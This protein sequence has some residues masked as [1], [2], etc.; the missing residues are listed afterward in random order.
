MSEKGKGPPAGCLSPEGKELVLPPDLSLEERWG[1]IGDDVAV[2]I[3]LEGLRPKFHSFPPLC[4]NPPSEALTCLRQTQEILKFVPD[5]LER[6][7]IR[8]V[9]EPAL[10]Y[11]S[12]MFTVAKKNG[13]RCPILDLS[14][15]NRLIVTPKFRMETLDKVVKLIVSSMWGTSIDITDAYLHVLINKGFQKYFSFILGVRTFVFL[16]MP[17]GLIP[18]FQANKGVSSSSRDNSLFIPR[19]FSYPSVVIPRG[20]STHQVDR[21]SFGVARLSDQ[22]RKVVSSPSPKAGISRHCVRSSFSNNF[23][24]SGQS[25]ESL[26]SLSSRSK[27]LLDVKKGIGKFGRFPEFCYQRP[28]VGK[29]FLNPLDKVDDRPHFRRVQGPPSLSGPCLEGGVKP[30]GRSEIPRTTSSY[31]CFRP[32]S[33][34]NDRRF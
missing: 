26:F 32:Y 15:L 13:K 19:R 5:W 9:T 20:V 4:L 14:R 7:I 12:K 18:G 22:Q 31:E 30:L 6:G 16:V 3:M 27:T 2:S 25:R 23:S 28:V 33:R 11:F 8:E 21:K 10:L 24:P 29:A 17:F 1:Y 34:Y